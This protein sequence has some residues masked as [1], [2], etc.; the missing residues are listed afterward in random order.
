MALLSRVLLLTCLLFVGLIATN[1]AT[2]EK[3]PKKNGDYCI[4]LAASGGG[5]RIYYQLGV[6][7]GMLMSNV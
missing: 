2:S 4:V 7:S 6:L 1:A 3:T 5:D